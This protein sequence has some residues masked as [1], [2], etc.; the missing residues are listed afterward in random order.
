M[1]MDSREFAIR[2]ISNSDKYA[3]RLR[4][5]AL[6]QI[7]DI[8]RADLVRVFRS[9]VWSEFTLGVYR[10]AKQILLLPEEDIDLKWILTE[11]LE[12][13]YRHSKVFSSIL[14]EMGEDGDI[15]TYEPTPGEKA[16]L[17]STLQYDDPIDIAAAFQVTGEVMLIE[18]LRHL[19]TLVEPP[20][21]E[22]IEKEV[23]LDEGRH[24]KNG[25]LLL[26]RYCTTEEK[27]RRVVEIS[28]KTFESLCGIY[29][30]DFYGSIKTEKAR[31][32]VHD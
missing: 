21:A 30:V 16:L 14:E 23:I 32:E 31:Y 7:T 19:K 13:E 10:P 29:G 25:R 18:I 17:Q 3:E 12:D 15:T 6:D 2:V 8:A 26:E 27:Q 5:Q 4:E 11:H 1:V 24:V 28:E 20:V 22:R 9:R